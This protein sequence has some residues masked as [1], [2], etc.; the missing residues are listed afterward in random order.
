MCSGQEAIEKTTHCHGSCADTG[1]CLHAGHLRLQ[2]PQ[3]KGDGS[4]KRYFLAPSPLKSE[5]PVTA[6]PRQFL[7]NTSNPNSQRQELCMHMGAN[8]GCSRFG[9]SGAESLVVESRVVP[10]CHVQRRLAEAWWGATRVRHAYAAV[11]CASLRFQ[12][13]TFKE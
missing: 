13:C 8:L 10:F 9:P 1:R 12:A 5:T 7:S 6:V 4:Q 11:R 3:K 2:Y